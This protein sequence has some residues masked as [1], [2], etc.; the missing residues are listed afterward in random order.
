MTTGGV[1]LKYYASQRID[2]RKAKAIDG[3]K[4]GPARGLR[5]R[6][7]VTKNKVGAP[8]GMT[9]FDILFDRGLDKVGC[10][11]DAAVQVLSL[12]VHISCLHTCCSRHININDTTCVSSA[13]VS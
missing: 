7:K 12:A 9:Q 11:V 3:E 10:L 6:A 4:D 8:F 5:I 13:C 2:V 1:A